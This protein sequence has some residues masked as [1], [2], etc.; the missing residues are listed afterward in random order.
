MFILKQVSKQYKVKK[1]TIK[2]LE[3]V[4]YSFSST[5]FYLITG[6]SG[7]GKS[8]LLN[9]IG[10]LEKPS[11]GQVEKKVDRKDIAY[12]FQDYN[13]I[14]D[15]TVKENLSFMGFSDDQIISTLQEV[16]LVGKEDT[17]AS[18]LSGGE[19]KRLAV[20]RAILKGSVVLLLDEPTDSLDPSNTHEM[21]RLL[22]RISNDKL[23]IVVSHDCKTAAMYADVIL[24]LDHGILCQTEGS[25]PQKE[26]LIESFDCNHAFSFRFQIRY[27]WRLL[28]RRPLF[29]LL[30]LLFLSCTFTLI[31]VVGSCKHIDQ[32]EVIY[33]Y[34]NE[35]PIERMP[36]FYQAYSEFCLQSKDLY[37]G[38]AL[39]EKMTRLYAEVV[40]YIQF[41]LTEDQS[42]CGK[43]YLV[44]DPILFRPT[45]FLK[46]YWKQTGTLSV[47]DNQVALE[48]L[49]PNFDFV[50]DLPVDG[51][52]KTSYSEKLL[53][54]TISSVK[55]LMGYE[56]LLTNRYLVGYMNIDYFQELLIEYHPRLFLNGFPNDSSTMKAYVTKGSWVLPAT[57]NQFG[58][59]ATNEIVCNTETSFFLA[60][61]TASSPNAILYDEVI[62]F[63]E[64]SPQYIVVEKSPDANTY[65]SMQLYQTIVQQLEYL[66]SGYAGKNPYQTDFADLI[67]TL[68]DENLK[69]DLFFI[70]SF[71]STSFVPSEELMKGISIAML[72][73]CTGF[74]LYVCLDTVQS[75][76]KDI[77]LLTTFGI[78]IKRIIW[79][80]IVGTLFKNILSLLLSTALSYLIL[81]IM[82][83]DIR[84]TADFYM[85][86]DI[87]SMYWGGFVLCFS[88]IFV[89]SVTGTL[90][91]F[92]INR[93]QDLA[94]AFKN[95]SS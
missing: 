32:D 25:I 63:Y 40:P 79:P 12:V 45:D 4:S 82:N 72:C 76:K 26:D 58:S 54:Q 51:V 90:F 24:H 95:T 8:T 43:I 57:E 83:H 94:V 81:F 23:V 41:P 33:H 20:G 50:A 3:E 87:L 86:C 66:V 84:N 64:F 47:S 56:D 92:M 73:L 2:A 67:R 89:L 55:F 37:R 14:G 5:G 30:E 91:L 9:I 31:L 77:L 7:S 88:W 69:P 74:I 65:I 78:P 85:N 17:K 70:R 52:I 15:W 46:A 10:G 13:L 62:N 39:K 36:V 59:L 44:D 75:R 19:A 16:N 61:D 38:P 60:K 29:L 93:R 71:Q 35:I 28:F 18:M 22:K 6:K 1:Q 11:S 34:M 42:V 80:F 53:S 49:S 21:F 48:L 27:G 68:E